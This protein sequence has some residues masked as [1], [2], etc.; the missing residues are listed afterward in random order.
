MHRAGL[1]H[2]FLDLRRLAP[3]HWLRGRLVA[4]PVSYAPMRADWT[5]VY[6]ALFFIDHMTST[7]PTNADA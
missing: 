6:D 4:R 5:R 1:K 3:E 2:A 7:A